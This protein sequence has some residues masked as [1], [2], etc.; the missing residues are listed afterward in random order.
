[1]IKN[2]LQ[3]K[4]KMLMMKTYQDRWKDNQLTCG[5]WWDEGKNSKR[6]RMRIGEKGKKVV[7]VGDQQ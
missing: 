2:T 3:P 4:K 7:V 1:M 5:G 6:R